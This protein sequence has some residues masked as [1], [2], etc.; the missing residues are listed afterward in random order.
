MNQFVVSLQ[1]PER[2]RRVYFRP[3]VHQHISLSF[4]LN[5]LI[6]QSDGI[7]SHRRQHVDNLRVGLSPL[8][9]GV[10]R[11]STVHSA[12][13]LSIPAVPSL[14]AIAPYFMSLLQS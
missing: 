1:G 5:R 7:R 2:Q 11:R 6:H 4:L 9:R 8:F 14:M 10:M 3:I 12:E 13:K